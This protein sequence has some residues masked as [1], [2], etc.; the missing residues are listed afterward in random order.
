[1]GDAVLRRLEGMV[2][3]RK[4]NLESTAVTDASIKSLLTLRGLRQLDLFNNPQ[5][6]PTRLTDLRALPNL[7]ELTFKTEGDASYWALRQAFPG[8][9]FSH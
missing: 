3:L 5:V 8:V 6:S 9:A 4:L 1:V 7:R 2:S